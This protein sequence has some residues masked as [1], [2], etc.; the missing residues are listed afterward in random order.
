MNSNAAGDAVDSPVAAAAV[1]VDDCRWIKT[2]GDHRHP[3]TRHHRCEIIN[4]YLM[5]NNQRLNQI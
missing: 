4:F 5:A 2:I 3:S 1:V